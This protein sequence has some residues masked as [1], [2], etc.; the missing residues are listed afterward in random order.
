MTSETKASRGASSGQT[1]PIAP[2][3]RS[4]RASRIWTGSRA[5]RRRICRRTPRRRRRAGSK[6]RPRPRRRARMRPS[7]PSAGRRTRRRGRRGSRRRSRAPAPG[8]ARSPGPRTPPWPRPRPHCGCPCGSRSPRA[9]SRA[10]SDR[11]PRSSRRN[12]PGLLAADVELRGAIDADRSV[13]RAN[14]RSRRPGALHARRG[15]LGRGPAPDRIGS[16]RTPARSSARSM[17]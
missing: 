7:S 15:R 8:C 13:V 3:A 6:R 14:A 16:S 1:I 2:Q 17:K 10:P 12:R 4:S 11:G 9:R 5:P